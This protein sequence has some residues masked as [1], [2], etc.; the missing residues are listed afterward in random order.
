V[1]ERE[2][3]NEQTGERESSRQNKG[4]KKMRG[5]ERQKEGE[6]ERE[7][8]RKRERE[9]NTHTSYIISVSVTVILTASSIPLT[10]THICSHTHANLLSHARTLTR[11]IIIITVAV[12]PL[13][14]P[15]EHTPAPIHFFSLLHT[16]TYSR[17][18]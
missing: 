8:E 5:S 9:R 10:L 16:H 7:R 11:H 1:R 15:L 13:L 18:T 2:G 3:G 6:R 14:L 17:G 4:E 12:I